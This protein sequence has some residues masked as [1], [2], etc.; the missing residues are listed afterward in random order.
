MESQTS[1]ESAISHRLNSGDAGHCKK[2][3]NPDLLGH[4]FFDG[5]NGNHKCL[6]RELPGSNIAD[7]K[8]YS[9]IQMFS[10]DA[11]RSIAA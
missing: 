2:I 1:Q 5:P 6:I 4:F 10:C 3:F 9:Y 8:A 7:R 11:A